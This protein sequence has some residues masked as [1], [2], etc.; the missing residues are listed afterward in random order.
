MFIQ[1]LLCKIDKN[2]LISEHQNSLAELRE[3]YK[4]NNIASLQEEI[5]KITEK[6]DNI[7]N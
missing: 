6:L 3:E 1:S 4:A 2:Q 7:K 5:N